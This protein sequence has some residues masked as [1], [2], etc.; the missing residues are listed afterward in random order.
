[1]NKQ[2]K[3]EIILQNLFYSCCRSHNVQCITAAKGNIRKLK[4]QDYCGWGTLK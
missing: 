1:M 4:M 3:S 2:Q